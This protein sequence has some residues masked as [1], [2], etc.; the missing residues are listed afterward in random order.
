MFYIRTRWRQLRTAAKLVFIGMHLNS[1]SDN[2]PIVTDPQNSKISE[3]NLDNK[4]LQIHAILLDEVLMKIRNVF[5][6]C[7]L[8][9]FYFM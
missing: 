5:S 4:S 1:S 9:W 7:I 6:F 8:I 3:T 2:K